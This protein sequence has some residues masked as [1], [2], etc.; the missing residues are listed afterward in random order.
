MTDFYFPIVNVVQDIVQLMGVNA[1]ETQHGMLVL[2]VCE[3]CLE[4]LTASRQH[5]FVCGHL[6]K[7]ITHQ[8]Y[9]VE[10]IL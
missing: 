3:D 8:C 2:A 1:I 5:Q 7:I 9:I 4:I 6:L 10:I